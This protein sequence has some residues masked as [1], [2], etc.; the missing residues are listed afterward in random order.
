MCMCDV[1]VWW[2]TGRVSGESSAAWR[3]RD[4][5]LVQQAGESRTEF[6]IALRVIASR[7]E[8]LREDR[9]SYS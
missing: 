7:V 9:F 6:S 2:V 5:L 4:E 3:Q 8:D 1:G